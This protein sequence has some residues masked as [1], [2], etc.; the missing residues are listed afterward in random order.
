MLDKDF[1][2]E[3][4]KEVEELLNDY[5]DWLNKEGYIDSDYYTEEPTAVLAYLELKQK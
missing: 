4:G 1:I 2:R 3:N 5:S